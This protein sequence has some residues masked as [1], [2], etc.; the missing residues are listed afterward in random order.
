MVAMTGPT[1]NAQRCATSLAILMTSIGC[2][3]APTQVP[4]TVVV[5]GASEVAP[6]SPAPP[7][8]FI[9]RGR[10]QRGHMSNGRVEG[11]LGAGPDLV[12]ARAGAPFGVKDDDVF[13]RIDLANG[14]P[15]LLAKADDDE[16]RT[17]GNT[18]YIITR[19][20]VFEVPHRSGAP[21]SVHRFVPTA[22]N[23]Y[24]YEVTITNGEVWARHRV[25]EDDRK[26]NVFIGYRL[27]ATEP[28][29][30]AVVF[31][32]VPE[33]A[34][35]VGPG[36]R[37]VLSASTDGASLGLWRGTEKVDRTTG[38]REALPLPELRSAPQKHSHYLAEEA[39]A[40]V[41]FAPTEIFVLS[42]TTTGY[43]VLAFPT[44]SD[45]PR[46]LYRVDDRRRDLPTHEALHD[47]VQ[48]DEHLYFQEPHWDW[49]RPDPGVRLVQLAKSGGT[50]RVLA[51]LPEPGRIWLHDGSVYFVGSVSAD[52]YRFPIR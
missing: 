34:F 35:F 2:G 37:A 49:T 51:T 9:A 13:V 16:L 27:G 43:E 32:R 18:L 33:R 46:R 19:D 20:Q 42:G 14:Q 4:Q 52:L 1:A 24:R 30:M 8:G 47:L 44:G 17:D 39:R 23:D 50:P 11:C 3:P 38:M 12:C 29:G 41:A 31:A 10:D 36:I 7:A 5:V 15:T 26:G 21:R 22:N 48:D 40:L 6:P 28:L 45:T 25:T